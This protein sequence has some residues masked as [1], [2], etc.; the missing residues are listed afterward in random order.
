MS[1]ASEKIENISQIEELQKLIKQR[2]AELSL[3]NSVQEA[4]KNRMDMQSIYEMVGEKIRELFDAQVAGISMFDFDKNTEVFKYGFENGKRYNFEPRPISGLRSYLIKT[5]KTLWLD[6]NVE[7]AIITITGKKAQ[8]VEG[9]EVPKCILYVPLLSNDAVQGYVTLQNTEKEN[10]F[11]S[12]DIN[13]LN[14]LAT[15]LSLGFENGNLLNQTEQRN[16]E[17]SVINSVQQGLVAEM[18]MQGIYDLVGERI[19]EVFNAEVTAIV[20]LNLDKEK[21]YFQ[22]ANEEGERIYPSPRKYD[23]VRRKIVDSCEPLL[24]NENAAEVMSEING[25]P[26]KPVPGTRMAKSALYVPLMVGSNING[27]VTLQNN[28]IENAFSEDDVRLLKTLANSMSVALENARLFNETEQRNA[29]LAVINSVQQGLVAEMDIQE[30]Y[31]LVGEKIRILFD[32]Q[33][34][35]IGT[36]DVEKEIEIFNYVFED[37]KRFY[38]EPRK[39]DNLRRHLIETQKLIHIKENATEARM[40]FGEKRNAAP[41]TKLPQSMIYVPLIIGDK[42]KGYV[43]LQNLERE[44]AFSDSDERLLST[45]ANSMSVALENARLFNETEQR[46]AELGVI[47]SV[48]QGLVAE[49]DMQGIYDLVGD[50]IRKVFNAQVTGIVTLNLDEEKEYFQYIHEEGERIYPPPRLYDNVRRKIIKDRKPL[51]IN[52]NAAEIMSNLNGKP[53]KAVP[54]T[55]MAKS[56]LYVPLLIGESVKGYVSLQNLDK[57]NAFSESDERLL[58]TLANSMSVALENARLFNETEQRNAELAVIN[59][60]QQGLVAEMDMQGIYDLVGE[61]IRQLFDAQVTAVA[62]FNYKNNTE[63]FHYIFEDGER[64]NMDPRPI[65]KFRQSLIDSK[66]LIYL[67]ENVDEMWTKITGEIPTVVPGT[68]FTKSA[69]YVPMI[70]GKEVRG[71]VSLQNVDKENAFS[72]SDIRLLGTLA[73]SMTVALENARL[74]NESEQRNAELAVINSVQE[75][76]VGVMDLQGVYDLVGSRLCDLFD[77]QAVAIASLKPDEGIEVFNFVYEN[78]SLHNPEPR[79][80]NEIRKNLIEAKEVIC[81]NTD[82]SKSANLIPG[83]KVPKSM[84]FVPLILGD[85]VEGYISLQN[86]DKENAFSESDIRLLSTLANSMTVALEN[87]HLFNETTR[88]LAETEQRASE[89]QTVNNISRA[90]V[91]QLE[92]DT[93]IKLVGEQML[94]TF[95]AD[96]VYLA[97]HDLKTNMLNFPYYYGDNPSTRPFGNGITEKIILSKKPLLI[98]E[99]MERAYEEIDAEKKG[100]SVQSYL[101]VP[102]IIGDIAIGVISVQSTERQNRFTENDLR[103]LNTIAANVSVAI[104]NAEAYEKLQAALN[105][106]ESAQEQLIQQEK[107]ASLGQLAAGIAHEIKNPLNFVNN[108]SELNLELIDEIYEELKLLPTDDH[109]KEIEGILDDITSNLKRIHQHGSRADSIVKSMLQH[110]RGSNGVQE[111]INLNDLVKEYVNLAFHGMRAGKKPINVS[112]DLQLEDGLSPISLISEDFSR[113]ILNLCNNAFDAMHEKINK[114]KHNQESYHPKL[115]VKTYIKGK[116]TI[117]EVTDNGLGIPEQLK[118]KIMQPFFTTKKGTEGTGLGLS[119][120][121]DIIKAHGGGLEVESQQGKESFTKFKISLIN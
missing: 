15:S 105:D 82:A 106:L 22:Y 2:E 96:I 64:F 89:M 41:G 58:T 118:A 103:L 14:T 25:Q 18:D 43:T 31:D 32:S 90:L 24:I 76:L 44:Y 93:L 40:R 85:K 59:S 38:L 62:T 37:G 121:N 116:N 57:E 107:L 108:F 110:S 61:R 101:G 9:T 79:P 86:L 84:L 56:V 35:A 100:K 78:G 98:N 97:I 83:T 70:V 8:P 55:K 104:Q 11:S 114:A 88:L 12:A 47:N 74:F 50:R 39:Y 53:F 112:I 3:I 4:I 94:E 45:L 75:G 67:N 66:E 29:E 72:E 63:E 5:K 117:L 6:R 99:D 21:E 36:F 27:Y 28:E 60:V 10:A 30:I 1:Q 111:N 119:I 80:Y 77:A 115:T 49:M 73:T 46:N 71:Y 52:Q 51:L 54:G 23:N 92:L 68:K 26:F 102:I 17:L 13:L 113:V 20:T 33:V 42:V 95:K 34:T 81:I 120:T 91:S 16:V 19:R 7:E 109:T 87:A 65:D 48:Q 69:L